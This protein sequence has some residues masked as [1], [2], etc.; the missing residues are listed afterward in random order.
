M[1]GNGQVA[2]QT[3]FEGPRHALPFRLRGIDSDN[4]SEFIN[5]HLWDYCQAQKLQFTRG[6]P[7]Q[8]DDNAH[9]EQKNWTHVRSCWGTCAMT[10]RRRRAQSRPRTA[11]I[12]GC[13]RTSSCPPSSC[14]ARSGSVRA[15]A[16]AMTPAD[17][18]RPRPRVRE[19]LRGRGRAPAAAARPPGS[20]CP[21][22]SIE[23]QLERIYAL[24]NPRYSPPSTPPEDARAPAP[25]VPRRVRK[26]LSIHPSP[27]L[28]RPARSVTSKTAR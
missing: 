25:P 4:G 10:A 19:D 22:R 12:S 15:S 24:A 2:V 13:S 17:P 7:Y 3:A 21:A 1:L 27:T 20:L 16:A 8:K 23:Q 5:Q 28:G 6:R 9:I 18:A 11:V 14:S 26:R